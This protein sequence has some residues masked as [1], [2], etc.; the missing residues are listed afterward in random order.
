VK[1]NLSCRDCEPE[2]T[3]YLDGEL[4]PAVTRA[5]EQHFVACES[6]RRK[7]AAYRVIAAGM[8]GLPEILPPAWLEERVVGVVTGRERARRILSRGMAIAAAASFAATIGL[9]A[10][11]PT[12]ARAFGLPGPMTWP[13]L[14]LRG[15]LGSVIAFLKQ[16][17]ALVAQWEPI[18]RLLWGSVRAL[19]AI[20]RA[21]LIALRTPEVQAAVTVAIALGVA[22]YFVLKPSRT[23]EGG[24]GHA[25]LML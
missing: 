3:A 1:T 20:P 4:H 10:Y 22:L 6:C 2:L 24:V 16:T 8:V 18:A 13:V 9:F 21:A 25:C 15:L 17:A 12:L 23:H 7:L 14:G 11:L 5:L 19:E